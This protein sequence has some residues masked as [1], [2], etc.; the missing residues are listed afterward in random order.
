MLEGNLIFPIF[1]YVL[2]C[3][4]INTFVSIQNSLVIVTKQE[5]EIYC[6]GNLSDG[7]WTQEVQTKSNT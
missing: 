3:L 6:F 5:F 2:M 4:V 1:A 7:R